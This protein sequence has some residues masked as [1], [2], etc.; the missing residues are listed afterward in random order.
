M[1]DALKSLVQGKV[2]VLV[3]FETKIDE[4]FPV[5]Q[6]LMEGYTTPLRADRNSQG[7]GLLICK[8]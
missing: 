3:I 5:N 1:F 6:F 8:R 4:S 7:G 2:D